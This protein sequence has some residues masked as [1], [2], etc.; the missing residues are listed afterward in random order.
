MAL[1][2]FYPCEGDGSSECFLTF[3]LDDDDAALAKAEVVLTAHLGARY[4][5]VWCGERK[6]VSPTDPYPALRVVTGHGASGNGAGA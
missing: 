5:A 3:D 1:Y 4:V 6:V 2:T